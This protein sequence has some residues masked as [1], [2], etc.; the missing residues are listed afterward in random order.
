M[1]GDYAKDTRDTSR[2]ADFANTLGRLFTDVIVMRRFAAND[3]SQADH[4]IVSSRLCEGLCGHRQFEAARHVGDRQMG[5][6][7]TQPYER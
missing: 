3:T 7:S 1:T 6:I 5:G 4:R 2:C